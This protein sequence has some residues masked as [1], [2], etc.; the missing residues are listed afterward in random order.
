[1]ADA[2]DRRA[3]AA[4][5]THY[6]H[7][8][9]AITAHSKGE[10]GGNAE[11]PR[12]TLNYKSNRRRAVSEERNGRVINRLRSET[13]TCKKLTAVMSV[14]T[15]SSCSRY[16]YSTRKLYTLISNYRARHSKVGEHTKAISYVGGTGRPDQ[17]RHLYPIRHSE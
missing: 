4:G 14:A 10:G 8:A 7:S 15:G 12:A 16:R 13:A 3:A 5:T 9:S 6:R 2:D 11:R 1:M 17:D